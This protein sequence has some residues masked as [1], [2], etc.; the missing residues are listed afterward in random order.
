MH[1]NEP[2]ASNWREVLRMNCTVVFCVRREAQAVTDVCPLEPVA[3]ANAANGCRGE[4]LAGGAGAEPL[5]S[6]VNDKIGK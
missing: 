3:P 5:P 4:A 2:A 1:I 6:L